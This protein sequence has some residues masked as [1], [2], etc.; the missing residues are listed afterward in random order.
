MNEFAIE[1]IKRELGELQ[2]ENK[3][4]RDK[5]KILVFVNRENEKLIE[6]YKVNREEIK[7][8]LALLIFK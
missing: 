7:R 8:E 3:A 5:N 2:N 6:A 1:N 4:L